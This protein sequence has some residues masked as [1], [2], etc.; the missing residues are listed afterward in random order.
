MRV[1]RKADTPAS[2]WE[3]K[4]QVPHEDALRLR[5][6]AAAPETTWDPCFEVDNAVRH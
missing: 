5:S 6:T 1:S 2:P 3:R 4:A